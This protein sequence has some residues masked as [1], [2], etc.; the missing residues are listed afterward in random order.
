MNTEGKGNPDAFMPVG[1]TCF[2][3]I[4]LPN[5]SSAAV[6]RRQLLYAI[7]HTQCIDA[8]EGTTAELQA[9]AAYIGRDED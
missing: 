2:L 4:D 3:R 6:L 7:T 9:Q 8:D 5:Y 1:H